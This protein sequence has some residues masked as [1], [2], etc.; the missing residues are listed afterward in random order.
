M[1][2]NDEW[3]ALSDQNSEKMIDA[4]RE[5][6]SNILC[7]GNNVKLLKS[8]LPESI[9]KGE[10]AGEVIANVMLSYRHLE[11]ARMRLGKVI[12]ALDG[13]VSVYNK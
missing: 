10:L 6:R 9:Q 5:L 11:D 3:D 2:D 13:G 1:S 8:R 7:T 4:C 12:Q